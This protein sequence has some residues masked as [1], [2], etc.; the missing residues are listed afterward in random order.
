MRFC[1]LC[2]KRN[3]YTDEFYFVCV[4]PFYNDIRALYFRPQWKTDLI[5]ACLFHNIMSNTDEESI[6]AISRYL[7]SAFA[8]RKDLLQLET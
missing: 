6:M 7:V 5:T 4:C 8:H 3:V 1:P 2:I